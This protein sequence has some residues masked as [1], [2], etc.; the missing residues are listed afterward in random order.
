MIRHLLLLGLLIITL[1]G[2]TQSEFSTIDK[3]SKEVPDSLT[4]YQDISS[5]LT[6]DL[7][8]DK[9]KIRALYIWIS[10]NIRYDLTLINSKKRYFSNAEIIDEVLA[11]KQGVCQHYAE[12]FHA[13]CKSIHIQSY[14]ISGYTRQGDG[15]IA[16]LSHAWNSVLVDSNYYFIDATWAAGYE[17]NNRYVHEFRDDYFLIEPEDFIKT[18]IPFDPIWQFLH[19]PIDNREFTEKD[20]SKLNVDGNFNYLDSIAKFEQS[21][22]L[23]QLDNATRRITNAS[24]TNPLIQYQIKENLLQITNIRYNLGIDTLN[25]GIDNYNLYISHKNRKFR[26]PKLDD[27]RIK[28]LIENAESGIY[29]ADKIFNNLYSD[30]IEL[31]DFIRVARNRMPELI[32]DLEREIDFVEKYLNKWKPLR[33]FMFYT[34]QY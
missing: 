23:A 9:E 5:Y 4:T 12:L 24:I 28:E 30:N 3:S 13:M 27:N 25:F 21:D 34:L 19:N 18:H 31:D 6:R 14:V 20:F 15:T 17:Y 33:G 26:N 10:H 32:S 16:S 7:T 11:S 1:Q 29:Q 22:K 2:F 8:S